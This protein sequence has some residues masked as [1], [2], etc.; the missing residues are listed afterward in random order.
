MLTVL[1][2]GSETSP[3]GRE[4]RVV[5]T[6][7]VDS[8]GA[9]S[10]STADRG[11]WSSSPQA[12]AAVAA[13]DLALAGSAQASAGVVAE[14]L[15]NVD[16]VRVRCVHAT[17]GCDANA[18]L[19]QLAQM[20]LFRRIVNSLYVPS[21]VLLA[22]EFADGLRLITV[23]V[24]CADQV[25]FEVLKQVA[26]DNAA[27]VAL[28]GEGALTD[29]QFDGVSLNAAALES[30]PR[31]KRAAVRDAQK[32]QLRLAA[33][34]CIE[35][36]WGSGLHTLRKC[37][38][39]V[40]KRTL[41]LPLS[42]LLVV[43]AVGNYSAGGVLTGRTCEERTQLAESLEAEGR[44][45]EAAALYR[46]ARASKRYFCRASICRAP[47]LTRLPRAQSLD[48][49]MHTPGAVPS[50]PLMWSYYGIALRK[51]GCTAEES[52]AA[53]EEGLTALEG[54]VYPDTPEDR[55]HIRIKL[56]DGMIKTYIMC[57]DDKA[58][59]KSAMMRLFSKLIGRPGDSNYQFGIISG[60]QATNELLCLRSKRCWRTVYNPDYS[61]MPLYRIE[62]FTP[63]SQQGIQLEK[64]MAMAAP[65]HRVPAAQAQRGAERRG[66]QTAALP[67]T[68]CSVCGKTPAKFCAICN[69][70]AYC[71]KACQVA[72]W[73]NHK[74]DP[75]CKAARAAAKAAAAGPA[76]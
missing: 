42:A 64:L 72:D 54:R 66:F 14:L 30:L 46:Q 36:Q 40:S 4:V 7:G 43:L 52:L 49:E 27:H 31:A 70:P 56:L 10:A 57:T 11:E 37:D 53:V 69:G 44:F 9:L 32:A 58:G 71:D 75:A 24:P 76:A 15:S 33:K 29:V 22:H 5:I 19:P 73:S 67:P 2:L 62:E 55:E 1:I 74:K 13:L 39:L 41:D 61:G 45:L 50:P 16:G 60:G 65:L 26:F 25:D 12:S 68:A 18:V 21:D 35:A 63:F 28:R 47:E 6:V 34:Q 48:D 23:V 38:A 59:L 8:S 17:Q 51:G 3:D 20:P